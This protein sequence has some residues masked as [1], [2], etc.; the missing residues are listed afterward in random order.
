MLSIKRAFFKE[1]R[2]SANKEVIPTPII[3][4]AR[5]RKRKSI[6]IYPQANN[7]SMFV[8]YLRLIGVAMGPCPRY[9]FLLCCFR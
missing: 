3:V 6:F 9:P 2:G 7:S 5:E 1:K 8:L 4:K